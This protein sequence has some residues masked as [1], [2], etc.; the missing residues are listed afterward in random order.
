MNDKLPKKFEIDFVRRTQTEVP[1]EGDVNVFRLVEKAEGGD[2]HIFITRPVDQT[3]ALAF[4][5][6][7]A[8]LERFGITKQ[9]A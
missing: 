6:G 5:L 2:M 7:R 8:I 3:D 4:D 1:P 9:E